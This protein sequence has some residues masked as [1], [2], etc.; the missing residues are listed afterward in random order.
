VAHAERALKAQLALDLHAVFGG[1]TGWL[2]AG[3]SLIVHVLPCSTR[4]GVPETP[5][6]NA[7]HPSE[8]R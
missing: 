5:A 3:A 4:S 7:I 6:L 1:K 8:V 2:T